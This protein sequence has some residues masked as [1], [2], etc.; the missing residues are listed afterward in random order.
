[1][2]ALI[3]QSEESTDTP[4]AEKYH[5]LNKEEVNFN[6]D[7]LVSYLQTL[8]GS[9]KDYE[10]A[11]A[12]GAHVRGF[13]QYT[14]PTRPSH[15]ALL[16]F[17]ALTDYFSFLKNER[18]FSATT[19]S[20]KL[21]A[22]RQAIDYVMYQQSEEGSHSTLTKCEQVKERLKKWGKALTKDIKKQR[23]QHALKC[24]HEVCNHL[25]IVTLPMFKFCSQ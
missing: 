25:A 19:I 6:I 18:K 20:D 13:F 24:S 12:I 10:P 15:A 4:I 17:H 7:G 1:M 11:K 23:T 3:F 14:P 2:F 5:F 9:N 21:R 8:D 16:D 22:I